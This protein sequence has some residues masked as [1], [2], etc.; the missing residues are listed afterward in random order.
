MQHMEKHEYQYLNSLNAFRKVDR[1][2]YPLRGF[3]PNILRFF[4]LF[5]N[6]HY[7]SE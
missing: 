5:C 7:S 3:K 2:I 6:E 1:D 4:L